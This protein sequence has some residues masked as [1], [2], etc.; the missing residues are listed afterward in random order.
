MIPTTPLCT[1]RISN[2][3]PISS[4]MNFDKL[5]EIVFNVL[6]QKWNLSCRSQGNKENEKSLENK[7]I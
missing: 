6:V 7:R 3:D 5:K 4:I 2:Q 1:R